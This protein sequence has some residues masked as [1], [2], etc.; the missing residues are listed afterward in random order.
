MLLVMKHKVIG[1]EDYY[2]VVKTFGFLYKDFHIECWCASSWG[3]GTRHDWPVS[4]TRILERQRPGLS[5]ARSILLL[6]GGLSEDCGA[7]Y[8]PRGSNKVLL[9]WCTE[10]P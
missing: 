10:N 4:G 1:K 2:T 6:R 9:V 8:P 3:V 7:L 5:L